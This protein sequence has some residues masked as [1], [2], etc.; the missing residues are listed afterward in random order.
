MSIEL[1]YNEVHTPSL[2]GCTFVTE[3][4]ALVCG[5]YAHVPLA[6]ASVCAILLVTS[7]GE[8]CSRWRVSFLQPEK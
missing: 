4:G 6:V 2:D 3:G 5:Y 8:L 1:A 7:K